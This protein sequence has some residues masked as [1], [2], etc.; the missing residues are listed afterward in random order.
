MENVGTLGS[1]AQPFDDPALSAG[2]TTP[3]VQYPDMVTVQC[4]DDG[5]FGYLQLAITSEPGPRIDDVGGDLTPEWGMHL[6]DANVAM[7]DIVALA[8]AQGAA[9]DNT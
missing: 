4:V 2:V 8:A 9:F 1:A 3:F 5:S 7:G 6:V